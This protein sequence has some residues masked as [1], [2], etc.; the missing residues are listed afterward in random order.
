[1]TSRNG[2]KYMDCHSSDPGS[3]FPDFII[4]FD[5]IKH[6]IILYNFASMTSAW[7]NSSHRRALTRQENH[8]TRQ[9]MGSNPRIE[10]HQA[11][12]TQQIFSTHQHLIN[13]EGNVEE[14]E[15]DDRQMAG[16]ERSK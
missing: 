10:S 4:K 11:I 3:I 16:E 12:F 2:Y 13:P 6:K 8:N 14:E 1:M 15:Y 9:D 7:N 5:K